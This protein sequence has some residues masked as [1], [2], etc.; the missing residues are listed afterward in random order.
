MYHDP[1]SMIAVELGSK[2]GSINRQTTVYS[3]I[4][5]WQLLLLGVAVSS[6]MYITRKS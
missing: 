3:Y 1:K 2:A 4:F 6:L 5:I